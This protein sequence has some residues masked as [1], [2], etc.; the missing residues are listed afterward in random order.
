MPGYSTFT[1]KSND[2]PPP[3]NST[4]PPTNVNAESSFRSNMAGFKWAQGVRRHP[5]FQTTSARPW[6]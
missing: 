5:R 6:R 1:R 4:M 2:P 3:T